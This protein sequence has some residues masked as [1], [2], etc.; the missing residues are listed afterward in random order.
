MRDC[1]WNISSITSR[2][3]AILFTCSPFSLA[4]YR[5]FRSIAAAATILHFSLSIAIYSG[6]SVPIIPRSSFSRSVRRCLGFWV[7]STSVSIVSRSPLFLQVSTQCPALLNLLLFVIPTLHI[8]F[9][10]TL[11]ATFYEFYSLL[12]NF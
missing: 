7:V 8:A 11:L 5:P 1:V 12:T 10:Y 2:V 9:L 3:N 4:F 6:F